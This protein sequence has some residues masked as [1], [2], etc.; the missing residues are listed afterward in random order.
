MRPISLPLAY[1][2]RHDR[3]ERTAS[4][5]LVPAGASRAATASDIVPPVAGSVPGDDPGRQPLPRRHALVLRPSEPPTRVAD[6]LLAIRRYTAN[7]GR[8]P[9]PPGSLVRIAV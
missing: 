3:P 4:R 8:S 9:F 2:P 7:A 5:S 1:L 6:A